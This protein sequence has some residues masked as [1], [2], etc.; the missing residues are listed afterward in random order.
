MDVKSASQAYPGLTVSPVSKTSGS[1]PLSPNDHPTCNAFT[2]GGA[3][4]DP[5]IISGVP[6]LLDHAPITGADLHTDGSFVTICP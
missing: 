1:N 2:S 4:V 3:V 5:G 6:F